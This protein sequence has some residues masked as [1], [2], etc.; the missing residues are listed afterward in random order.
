MDLSISARLVTVALAEGTRWIGFAEGD[1]DEPYAL[2][3]QGS[4]GGP[5]RFE[6]N[7]ELFA[8]DDAAARV[9]LSPGALTVD[10]A[11]E[12][13]ETFGFASR[14]TIRLGPRTEGWPEAL[15]ALRRMLGARLIEPATG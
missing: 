8:A 1:E 14:V 4:K 13:A 11:P 3:A 15:P 6:V 5:V 7:D 9:T 2:F 10:L 12:V